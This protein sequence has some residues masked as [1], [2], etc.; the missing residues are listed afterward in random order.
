MEEGCYLLYLIIYQIH[1]LFNLFFGEGPQ[2]WML[3]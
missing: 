1:V 2:T 3:F